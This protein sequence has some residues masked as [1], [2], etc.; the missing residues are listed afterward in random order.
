VDADHITPATVDAYI[1]SS[2][3]FTIDIADSIGK[4]PPGPLKSSFLLAM[5]QNRGSHE[6]PGLQEKVEVTDAV[7][8]N[9]ASTYLYGIA[10]AGNVY[11]RIAEKKGEGRFITEVSF[12]EPEASTGSMC[13]S[14][15]LSRGAL[16]RPSRRSSRDLF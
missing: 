13:S 5:N 14:G 15:A 1:P 10:A 2:D 16:S 9:F 8:E 12:D 3:F 4:P 6:I 7:L 11:R